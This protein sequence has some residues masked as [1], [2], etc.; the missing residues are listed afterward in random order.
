MTA[1]WRFEPPGPCSQ[2]NS[3]SCFL[4]GGQANS[5]PLPTIHTKGT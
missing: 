4:L 5:P 1:G 3:G 2:K